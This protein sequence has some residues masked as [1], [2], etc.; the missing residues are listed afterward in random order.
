MGPA[1]GEG[2]GGGVV[3]VYVEG[4]GVFDPFALEVGGLEDE[5]LV[6]A[7]EDGALA[8]GVDEDEGV[9]AGSAGDGGDAGF[10][11]GVAEGFAM[12]GRRLRRRRVCRRSGW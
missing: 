2:G 11:A 4:A 6:A 1:C 12:K 7:A 5:A 10:D 9:G 8:C 3:A